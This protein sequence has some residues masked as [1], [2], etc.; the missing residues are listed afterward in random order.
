MLDAREMLG[1]SILIVD[2]QE[3]NVTLLDAVT[4]APAFFGSDCQPNVA[5]VWLFDLSFM[6]ASNSVP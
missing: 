1:A 6:K 3:P 5:F 4:T 2:D